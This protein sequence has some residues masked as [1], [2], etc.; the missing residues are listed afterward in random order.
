MV[1]PSVSATALR[2]SSKLSI[3]LSEIEVRVTTSGGPGGQHANRSLTKVVV[4]FD[5]EASTTL[6]AADKEM[7]IEKLGP[8]V[9]SRASRYRSQTQNKQAALEQLAIKLHEA[10]QRPVERRATKPTKGSKVR[11]IDQ[12]KARGEI[13]ANRR[14]PVDD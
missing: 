13:K 8:V 14:R 4:G 6:R 2:L 9:R 7:L 5:V 10:L 3:P 12:K 1:N 11:R